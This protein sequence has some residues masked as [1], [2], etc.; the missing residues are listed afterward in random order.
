MTTQ[1]VSANAHE[2]IKIAA[3]IER[4]PYSPWH[5]K[6]R[7]I[8]GVAT[9]F[10]AFD[11][12]AIA[13]VLPQLL[14]EWKFSPAQIGPLF[15]IGFAGQA[16]GAL[17]FGWLAER[18]GRVRMTMVT[19]LIFA[20]MSLLC[21]NA[22]NY[23]QL[24]WYRF[25][26][27]IGLGGEVPL[28]AAYINEIAKSKG[29]GR[30]FLFYEAVFPAGL[31]VVALAAAWI[32][33]TYGW[34]WMFYIGAIPAFIVIVMRV[35]CPESPRWLISRG[36]QA[37]AEEAMARIEAAVSRNGARPLPPIPDLAVPPA[38][39]RTSILELF[40]SIYLKRTVIVSL[41]WICA[42][43]VTYGLMVWLP[44]LYR[45]MY[46][47]SVQDSINYSLLMQVMSLISF[48]VAA[49][50]IDRVGRKRMF[51]FCFIV[52][53][54]PLFA[55][56]YLQG[57]TADSVRILAALSMLFISVCSG[58]LYLYV[59]ELY[60]TR[61]RALGTAWSTFWLRTASIFGP[62]I[63]GWILPI[64]GTAGVFLFV[65]LVAL[66]GGIICTIFAEETAGKVLEE[67]S[68]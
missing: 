68:P 17:L 67:I 63:V 50:V 10:D 14:G 56:W 49:S 18:Y 45:T 29:R 46:N 37:E 58:A 31:L 34:R 55:L 16:I 65:G 2:E 42:Y 54:L 57:G 6:M 5:I 1:N 15:S 51:A 53:S 22:Q 43:M 61:M 26:Q 47:L 27:G 3:R 8:L 12:L 20:I 7:V 60:P 13:Y 52:G 33:P 4:L 30:F 9:F 24:F 38:K 21:A 36:R 28:A 41:L 23:D 40:Q 35:W 64:G 59:P 32:V 48:L 39:P 44:T 25:V 11:A 66:A 19:V 62:L